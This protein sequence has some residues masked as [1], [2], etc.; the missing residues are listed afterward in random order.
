MLASSPP[1]PSGH[2]LFEGIVR[3]VGDAI[4]FADRE[5]VIRVWNRG[6][7][8]LFGF[9]ASEAVGR[10]LDLIVPERFRQAHWA[11][12]D[13]AIAQGRGQHE[14]QVRTTRALHGDGRKL[15]VDMSFGVVT[16]GDGS[17]LGSVAMARDATARREAEAALRARIEALTRDVSDGGDSEPAP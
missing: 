2:D 5:G 15:Y 16:G 10:S 12:F 6:A 4:V 13:R 1:D 17:V 8:A 3:Q 11:A 14:G 9:A 7:E